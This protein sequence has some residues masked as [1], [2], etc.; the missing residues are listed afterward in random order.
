MKYG[1][2]VSNSNLSLI[3]WYEKNANS[4]SLDDIKGKINKIY[5]DIISKDNATINKYNEQM[6][7][8]NNGLAEFDSYTQDNLPQIQKTFDEANKFLAEVA[9][10][11][12]KPEIKE[13]HNNDG[14]Y[15]WK[16]VILSD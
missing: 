14:N 2:H 6:T 4:W 11:S 1:W 12:P 9:N 15:D 3:E 7:A 8:Y 16:K 5:T 13:G 10:M